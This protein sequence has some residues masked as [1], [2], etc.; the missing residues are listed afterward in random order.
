TTGLE[1]SFETIHREQVRTL[2]LHEV[3]AQYGTE[4]LY[5]RLNDSLERHNLDNVPEVAWA[6]DF[7][8]MLHAEQMRSNGRY[9]DHLMRVTTRI[10]DHFEVTDPTIIAGAILHDSVEDHASRICFLL[11]GE[12]ITDERRARV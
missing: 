5:V 1:H 4:G 8:L 11:A 7:A 10:I 9:I 3:T 12:E 2:A 6:V